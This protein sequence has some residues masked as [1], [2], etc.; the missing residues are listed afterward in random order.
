MHNMLTAARAGKMP[1]TLL[2]W[3]CGDW[4]TDPDFQDLD[5]SAEDR[6]NP[7]KGTFADLDY[8]AHAKANLEPIPTECFT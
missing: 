3:Y 4:S 7:S 5:M 1:R 6:A 2:S 8:L